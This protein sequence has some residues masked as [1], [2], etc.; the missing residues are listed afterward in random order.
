MILG[1]EGVILSDSLY[2]LID[3]QVQ[4]G[5]KALSNK[6]VDTEMYRF[7]PVV[8]AEIEYFDSK[9]GTSFLAEEEITLSE[10]L[11]LSKEYQRIVGSLLRCTDGSSTVY[12]L[13]HKYGIGTIPCRKLDR[14][15]YLS[16]KQYDELNKYEKNYNIAYILN[17]S[18]FNKNYTVTD[19]GMVNEIG[20]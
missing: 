20:H 6:G 19:I 7:I 5:K 10:I 17:V 2:I 14:F 4:I 18:N 1:Q 15:P 8:M 12:Y 11:L 9:V 13:S 16:D 3:E